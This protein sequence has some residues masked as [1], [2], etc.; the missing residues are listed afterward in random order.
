MYIDIPVLEHIIDKHYFVCFKISFKLTA[1]IYTNKI[2]VNSNVIQNNTQISGSS[3]GE[4][5]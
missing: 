5:S 1:C 3:S 2:W 4:G